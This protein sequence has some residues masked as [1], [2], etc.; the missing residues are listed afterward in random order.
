MSSTPI[1]HL[2]PD[3]GNVL[4]TNGWDRPSRRD[5][6]QSFGLDQED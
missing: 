6:A 2:F 1:T 5:A 3:I 4:L